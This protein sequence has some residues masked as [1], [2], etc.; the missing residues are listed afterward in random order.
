MEQNEGSNA[1]AAAAFVAPGQ[2]EAKSVQGSQVPQDKGRATA[3]GSSSSTPV[4]GKG[5]EWTAASW[6]KGGGHGESEAGE[7]GATGS[8]LSIMQKLLLPVAAV[9]SMDAT[10]ASDGD[11]MLKENVRDA[12]R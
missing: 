4:Q 3:E 2:G 12:V 5:D 8:E 11:A 10:D 6:S 9:M 1:A 7:G